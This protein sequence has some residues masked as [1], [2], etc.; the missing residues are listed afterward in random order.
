TD[1]GMRNRS[2]EI[3]LV[4]ECLSG[5]EEAWNDLYHGYVALVRKTI[6][7]KSVLLPHDVDDLVQSTFLELVESVHGYDHSWS[8]ARF[9]CVI[10]ERTVAQEFRRRAAAKRGGGPAPVRYVEDYG[11][12]GIEMIP[13]S[14]LLEDAFAQAELK[15]L[16]RRGLGTLDPKCRELLRL[17]YVEQL[18]FKEIAELLGS[19]EKSL[20]VQTRRCLDALRTAL[21]RLTRAGK[22]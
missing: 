20:S 5:S 13:D 2:D 4:S 18:P 1:M 12:T 14:R 15:V 8:L 3:Q 21:R 6:Q 7:R 22:R 16:L 9:I 10:A 17:R 11:E 19:R